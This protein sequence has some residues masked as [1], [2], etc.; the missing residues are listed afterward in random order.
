MDTHRQY[1]ISVLVLFTIAM[2]NLFLV[3]FHAGWA[4]REVYEE[5]ILLMLLTVLL[6]PVFVLILANL[7]ERI[8]HLVIFIVGIMH[9]VISYVLVLLV[10][11]FLIPYNLRLDRVLFIMFFLL[12]ASAES[13]AMI[14]FAE[15][16]RLSR[17]VGWKSWSLLVVAGVAT[18]GLSTAAFIPLGFKGWLA[19]FMVSN[20]IVPTA[21]LAFFLLYPRFHEQ[22]IRQPTTPPFTR[23]YFVSDPLKGGKLALLTIQTCVYAVLM[24]GLSGLGLPDSSFPGRNWT[25]YLGIIIGAAIGLPLLLLF[26]R[27]F[28]KTPGSKRNDVLSQVA[29][30]P[31]LVLSPLFFFVLIHD[32]VVP[33]MHGSAEGLIILGLATGLL[34][35]TFFAAIPVHFPPRSYNAMYMLLFFFLVFSIVTGNYLKGVPVNAEDFAAIV[36]YAEYFGYL[37][38]AVA[39]IEIPLIVIT[40]CVKYF[41]SK[42]ISIKGGA[43]VEA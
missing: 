10:P 29:W 21:L 17:M 35:M 11:N 6:V 34:L 15:M 43:L 37:M 23:P 39:L 36:D 31:G 27:L 26:S 33:G 13:L 12:V 32:L 22:E 3:T 16:T 7:N 40:I 24:F 1:S 9:V 38:I 19:Y 42:K 14:A 25:Y 41:Q 30:V 18:A 20:I 2:V 5:D 28:F 4:F 8:K